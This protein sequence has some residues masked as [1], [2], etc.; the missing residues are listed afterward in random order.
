MIGQRINLDATEGFAAKPLSADLARH[1]LHVSF[2]VM[3]VI[4]GAGLA[5]FAAFDVA[6]PREG[7]QARAE[8]IVQQPHFVLPMT[9]DAIRAPN[10]TGS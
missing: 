7:V 8:M 6:P 5:M 1:Q 2:G 10:Q 4:V 9:A 3:G